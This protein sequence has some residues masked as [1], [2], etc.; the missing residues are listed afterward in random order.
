MDET[1]RKKATMPTPSKRATAA[2]NAARGEGALFYAYPT[3]H[4]PITIRSFNGAVTDVALGDVQLDG[5]RKPSAATN[6]AATQ[7]QEYLAGKRR[8]FDLRLDLC[9]SDFQQE[10]WR[11]VAEIPYGTCLTCAQLAER[12]GRTG[13]HRAVGAAVRAN[14]L[15]II[16]PA[17]RV[18]SANGKPLGTGRPAAVKGALLKMEMDNLAK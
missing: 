15:A 3:P 5:M 4:G 16:V 10:A 11:A 18:T 2:A 9:G 1:D 6:A 12:M 8:A 17:H 13:S 7:I 14:P